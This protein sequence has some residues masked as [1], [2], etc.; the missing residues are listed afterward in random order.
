MGR[1]VDHYNNVVDNTSFDS[2]ERD[3][4]INNNKKLEIENKKL[5]SSLESQT[6]EFNKLNKTLQSVI[7]HRIKTLEKIN[8][9]SI[10]KMNTIN[11]NTNST[12]FHYTGVGVP[13]ALD[14]IRVYLY[15]LEIF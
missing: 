3:K 12:K 4:L 5:K 2:D 11:T 14:T 10:T 15:K 6:L 9:P 13:E 7:N 1:L 8:E